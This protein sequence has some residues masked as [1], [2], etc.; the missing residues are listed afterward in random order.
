MQQNANLVRSIA[1]GMVLLVSA[2]DLPH[3]E[4]HQAK[5]AAGRE[6]ATIVG[7]WRGTSDCAVAGSACH[8]EINVYRFS[9]VAGKPGK[10]R[11]TASKVV[12]GK[13]SVMGSGE[14]SY[15]PTK[16]TLQ[17]VSPNPAIRMSVDGDKMEGS[18]T[19]QDRT[20]Y[21]RIHLKKAAAEAK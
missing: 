13:E 2:G 14:W 17:T 15:D 6:E 7:T 12:D 18:L 16:H 20:V 19:L 11:C 21:R 3:A 10:F 5:P 1:A 9:E 8:D 4:G